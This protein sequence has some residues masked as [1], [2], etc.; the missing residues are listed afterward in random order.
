MKNFANVCRSG[1]TII[2][3]ELTADLGSRLLDITPLQTGSEVTTRSS[4]VS[5]FPSVTLI[6]KV[7]RIL[8]QIIITVPDKHL[9]S[10]LISK[11]SLYL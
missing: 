11:V 10:S 5:P 6:L 1:E 7:L 4:D 2:L 3:F 8:C 9:F